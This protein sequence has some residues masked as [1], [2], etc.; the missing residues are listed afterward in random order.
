MQR[1]NM[2]YQSC[3]MTESLNINILV[4]RQSFDDNLML[5]S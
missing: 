2:R 3:V 1:Q 4:G 5:R